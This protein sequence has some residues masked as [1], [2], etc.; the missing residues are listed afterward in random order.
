[1][2]CSCDYIS[3]APGDS[4]TREGLGRIKILRNI[5]WGYE[6]GRSFDTIEAIE[7]EHG[8]W[9]LECKASLYTG[10]NEDK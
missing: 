3:L 8:I 10:V 6:C 7:N 5:T 4:R 1:M 2:G 9:N